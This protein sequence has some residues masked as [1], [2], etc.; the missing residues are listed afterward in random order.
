MKEIGGYFGLELRKGK[1]FHEN[2]ISLNTGRNC[3]EYILRARGYKKIYLPYFTCDV[4]LEPILKLGLTYEF[5]SIDEQLN[6]VFAKELYNDEVFLYTNYFGIKTTKVRDLGMSVKNL[7]IDN[8]QAFF[9]EPIN[10]ID[11]FYSARKFFGVTDGA[12]LYTNVVLPN[13]FEQDISYNRF[14]HLLKRIDLEATEGYT[15]FKENDFNL[16]NQPIKQMSKLTKAILSSIDYDKTRTIRKRNFEYFHSIF[17]AENKLSIDINSEDVP[18]IY[19][20]WLTKA[21][22]KENLLKNNIFIATYWPNVLDWCD[23]EDFEYQ[24]TTEIVPLPIDQRY[25]I[26]DMNI[27][28]DLIL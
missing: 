6:P 20:L 21:G 11:T 19:P 1:E 9:T 7:I 2:A 17:N 14:G 4:I 3:L 26:E 25:G 28:L 16:I 22:L 18:M 13:K 15:D 12:Y 23:K 10:N 8:T 24:L 27:I 5:Y